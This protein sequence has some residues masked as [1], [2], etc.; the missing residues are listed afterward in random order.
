MVNVCYFMAQCKLKT[1][2]AKSKNEIFCSNYQEKVREAVS[3]LAA[4]EEK[5][6]KLLIDTENETYYQKCKV[7][8]VSYLT[9]FAKRNI[10]NILRNI[11]FHLHYLN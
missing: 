10:K 6:A 1:R 9:V 5:L 11:A 7:S 2:L 3:W 4:Q 8:C